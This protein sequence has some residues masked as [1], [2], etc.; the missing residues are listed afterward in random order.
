VK[1][2]RFGLSRGVRLTCAPLLVMFLGSMSSSQTVSSVTLNP[3]SV[4]AVVSTT[5]TVTLAAAAPAGGVVVKLSSNRPAL[6]QMPTTVT[7][8]ANAL[9][10]N[11]TVNTFPSANQE[12]VTITGTFKT[13]SQVGTLTIRVPLMGSA[14]GGFLGDNNLATE[15]CIEFPQFGGIDGKGNIFIA[16]SFGDRIRRIGIG[17]GKITTVAGVGQYGY[18]GEGIKATTTAMGFPRG[19]VVNAAGEFWYSDPG[20]N[21]V[22]MVNASNIVNTVAG[23]GFAGYSG[24][25]GPAT[26]AQVNQP[27]GLALDASGNL[28]FSDAG[29]NVVRMVDGSGNIHTIAGTGTAGFSG[30][31]GPATSANLDSPHGLAFD[32]TG[33]LY[34]VD[35]LNNRVRIVTGLGTG[36]VTINT[37]AGTGGTAEN[38]DGGLATS[39][40][41]GFPRGV[42][43]ANGTLYISTAGQARIRAVNLTSKVINTVAGSTAGYDG[44]GNPPLNSMFLAPTGLM[45]D[46]KGELLVVDTGNDRV[47]KLNATDTSVS[48]SIGGFVGDGGIAT[49]GCLNSPENVAFDPSGNFYV[50]EGNGNRI[51]EVSAGNISTLAGTGVTGYSGDSGAANAAKINAPQG[52]AAD[53]F[54]NVYIADNGNNVIRVVT[55]GTITTFDQDPTFKN[56]ASL[57]TDSAG[58]V[59]SVDTG[60]CVV[61]EITPAGSSTIVAGILNGCGYNADGIAATSAQL[62]QPYGVA[63]DTAGNIYIGDSGNNRVRKVII[64]TGFIATI[65]GTG[66]CGFSGDAGPATSAE[67]C[68]PSGVAV[69]SL[70]RVFIADYSNFRVRFI[71]TNG[72]ISTYAG[73]GLPGYNNNGRLATKTNL[74]GPIGVALGPSNVLYVSDDQSYRVRVIE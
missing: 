17:T 25:G 27:N 4:P 66:T 16:D 67:L 74:G 19:L 69:D 68:S 10:A 23:N 36:T 21:R 44:D 51:R 54:G 56:L 50:A 18:N 14:A 34:I 49:N 22:R 61:R 31:G 47:R 1:M 3:A 62:S 13:S 2:F 38:G 26:S 30:D 7:V 20:N 5:G 60:A 24:D 73:T 42:L 72:N 48:T 64:S 41:V 59:Y 8:P 70:G 32:T 45:M 29:N 28:Y 57:T 58:N 39:A 9:S 12:T 37:Y 52:V 6:L 63:L 43:V 65:A 40:S 15:A 35:A 53:R 55:A 11:F 71:S 33:N 46:S